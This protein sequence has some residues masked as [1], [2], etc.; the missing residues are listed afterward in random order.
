M[1]RFLI[2][3]SAL[4]VSLGAW[5]QGGVE[6]LRAM[7]QRVAELAPYRI[8]FSLEMP[9]AE[10]GSDGYCLVDGERYVIGIE[11]LRQGYD[12]E[13]VWTVNGLN[14]EITLDEPKPQSRSLFDNP[15]RAF[16]FEEGMF[17]IVGFD[18]GGGG[19]W[20]V[21]LRPAEGVL[22]GIER[23]VLEVSRATN[24][25]T[26]LGYDMGGVGLFVRIKKFAHTTPTDGD[27]A[28]PVIEGFEVIDF[29]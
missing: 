6:V 1:K 28:Q 13:S 17:E 9:G 14:S 8:E 29:R 19:V 16:D 12:G 7:S 21:V 5:A 24:L 3:L 22:D 4:A 15:T 20:K 10:S 23:V 26:L 27:F 2:I 18:E 11:E 25:P